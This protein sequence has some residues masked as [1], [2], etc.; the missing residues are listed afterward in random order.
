[1]SYTI[2]FKNS[3]S[4]QLRQLPKNMLGKV[5]SAID[6]LADEPRPVNCKKLKDATDSYRIRIGDYRVIYTVDDV[7]VTVEVV[8]VGNRKDIYE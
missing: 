6:D 4:K 5:A 3:A 1:M 8:K 2:L 7:T